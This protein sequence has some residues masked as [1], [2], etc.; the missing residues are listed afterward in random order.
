MS[1]SPTPTN[2]TADAET[3]TCNAY[4]VPG[5]T[6]VL[7]DAGAM[8]GTVDALETLTDQLAAVVITHQHA[9]HIENAVAVCEA[10]DAE[11]WAYD[12]HPQR[13]RAL[14][15][16]EDIQLGDTIYEV[17]HTPGHADDHIAFIGSQRLFSGDVVVY[18]DGAF[19]DGSFG[20]TDLPGQSREQLIQS[21]KVLQTRLPDS[22]T[23]LYPGHGPTF[24]GDVQSVL[25]QALRRAQRREPKYQ[26]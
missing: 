21:L 16:G 26:E 12:D 19:E 15:D 13:D 3:F 4:F 14:V 17:C 7:V 10:F 11:L 2:V 9:D 1:H 8:D 23:E 25:S 18:S 22:V 6:P 20:R 24:E 5:D